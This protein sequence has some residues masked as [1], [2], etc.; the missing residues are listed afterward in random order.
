VREMTL[1]AEEFIRRFLLHVLPEGFVRIRHY[2]LFANRH[3]AGNL[4]RCRELLTGAAEL[5]AAEAPA[6]EAW[7]T[8]LARL[9]G[10]DPSLCPK[11]G[12]GHLHRVEELEP[13]PYG[14]MPGR[15]PP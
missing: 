5:G 6:R 11:C 4:A 3:R 2:G 7:Q 9:T 8:R 12:L 1:P 13:V 15:S 10:K 14:G